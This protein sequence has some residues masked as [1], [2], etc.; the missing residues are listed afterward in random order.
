MAFGWDVD[1]DVVDENIKE[2]FDYDGLESFEH[3][4]TSESG[5]KIVAFGKYG[6]DG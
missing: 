6:Y 1:D 4:Y 5:D 3:Y 2:Y